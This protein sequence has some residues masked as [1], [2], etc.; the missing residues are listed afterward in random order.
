MNVHRP[1]IRFALLTLACGLA[2]ACGGDI[3]APR[4]QPGIA[5]A[6]FARVLGDLVLARVET[7]PDTAAYQRQRKAILRE[8]DVSTL[9]LYRFVES[10]GGDSDLMAT[11]YQ[12][13]EVRLD[14]LAVRRNRGVQ[15]T[16]PSSPDSSR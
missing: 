4:V 1:S 16:F 15:P 10:Q 2:P 5:P 12:R 3:S 7:L 13:A 11:I 14:T 9:D 8:A 6:T